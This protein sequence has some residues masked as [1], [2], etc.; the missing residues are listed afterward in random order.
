[1]SQ[2]IKDWLHNNGITC[3]DFPPY[4][5]DL[6]PSENLWSDVARRVE[7]HQAPSP[8]QLQDVVAEKW[9]ETAKK[10]LIQLAHS[11]PKRCR[12]VIKAKGAYIDY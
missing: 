12:A 6:N 3:L 1:M 4:S 10:L 8:E 9:Q 11:M 2:Q 5:P 7:K